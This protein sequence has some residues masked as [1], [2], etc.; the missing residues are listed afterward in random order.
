MDEEKTLPNLNTFFSGIGKQFWNN[1]ASLLMTAWVFSELVRKDVL[2][3]MVG[4]Q[5]MFKGGN[6]N[7]K[8]IFWNSVKVQ[9]FCIQPN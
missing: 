8:I 1:K 4:G 5:R 6:I 7:I 9:A 3:H 2:T